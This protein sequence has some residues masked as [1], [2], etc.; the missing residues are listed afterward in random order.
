MLLHNFRRSPLGP[1]AVHKKELFRKSKFCPEREKKKKKGGGGLKACYLWGESRDSKGEKSDITMVMP[2]SVI[3]A[4]TPKVYTT[5]LSS[6]S[7]SYH[8][9]INQTRS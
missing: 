5:T 2:C 6:G 3:L 4:Y 8:I 7:Y 9:I 1:R